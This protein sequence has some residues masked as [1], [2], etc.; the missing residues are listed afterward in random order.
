M[1]DRAWGARARSGTC[2]PSRSIW[3]GRRGS[4]RGNRWL[5]VAPLLSA[6]VKSPKLRRTRARVALGSSELGRGEEGATANSMAGKRPWIHGQRGEN[7]GERVSGGVTP[8]VSISCYVG[9]FTLISDAQWKFLFPY[10]IYLHLSSYSWM[11]HQIWNYS[12]SRITK[13]GAC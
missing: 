9:R 10:H 1:R 12:I 4:D 6:V 3:I 5:R 13:F 11:F 7:S 8:H 2:G